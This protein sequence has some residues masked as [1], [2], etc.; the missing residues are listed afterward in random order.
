MLKNQFYFF[1]GGG[2]MGERMRSTDWSQTPLGN[3]EIWPQSLK[4]I[5]SVVLNN[6][7]GMY[8]AWGKEYIQIYNDGYRSILGMPEHP[9]ALG[10]SMRDAFSENWHIIE[11]NFDDVMAGRPLGFPDLTLPL[12]RIGNFENCYYDFSYSPIHLENGE[13]GG[14]LVTVLETTAKKNTQNELNESEKRF[15]TMADNIP[16][17]S[18]MA[19]PDGSVYWYNNKW[20]EYTGTT[21]ETMQGW[22]WQ[23]VYKE[24]ELTGILEEWNESL[25]LGTAFEMIYPIKGKDGLYRQFL[26]RALPVKNEQGLI[27]TWFGTNTDITAQKEAE[28]ELSNSKNKLEFVIEAAK[29][30]TFDYNFISGSLSVN[31]RLKKWFG[32]PAHEEINLKAALNAVAENDKLKVL[33][34]FRKIVK[35]QCDQNHDIAIKVINPISKKEITLNAKFKAFFTQEKQ[36]FSFNGTLE[37][38]TIQSVAQRKLELSESKLRLMILQAP[39]AIAILRGEDYEVE[40][41][42][43]YALELWGKTEEEILNVSIFKAIP[44]LISQGMKSIMDDVITS[45]NRLAIS[46]LP[47]EIIRDGKLKTVYVNFSYEPLFD[48]VGKASGIM[49]IGLDVTKQVLAHQEIQKKE[50]SIR[51]L[52]ESAP[53]PIGVYTGKEMRITFANQSIISSWGTDKDVIGKLYSEIFPEFENQNVY[54]KLEKVFTTGIDF[55]A[56]NQR[57]DVVRDGALQTSYFNYSFTPL[58]DLNGVIYGVMHTAAEVTEIHES[59]E[60]IEESEKRF[61]V[62]VHQAPVAIAIFRGKDNVVEVANK[63]YLELIGKEEVDF[64]GQPLFESLPEIEESIGTIIADIYKTKKAFYGYEFPVPL[65][66]YGK[67]ES[68]FFNF[69][70]HPLKEGKIVTGIMVVATEVTEN[71]YAKK[72]LEENEQRLNIVI[73][74]SGLAIWELDISSDEVQISDRGIEILGLPNQKYINHAQLISKI[75]PDDLVLRKLAFER[76]L[77]TGILHYEIRT[78][79]DD[80]IHWIEAKG[81]VF[82]DEAGKA[83]RILGTLRE[84]TEVKN[85]QIQLLEREQKFRLLAD[86][87]PQF[88]WTA[89]PEGQLN[90]FNQSV[91]D[92]SGYSPEEL[93][94]KGWSDI[95]HVEDRKENISKWMKS[96]LTEKDFLME[97][98]FRK[99]DGSYRW[100]LSRAIPQRDQDGKI[101][102]W[103][104]TSTDIQDQKMFTNELEKQVSQRTRQLHKKNEVLEKMNKELQSFTY[105]SSHDLQEPLRKIQIFASQINDFESKNL[106]DSGK[107]KFRRMQ[108]AAN[109]MQTLIQ[110]LLAYSR[111]TD[112]ERTF[113]MATISQIVEEVKEDLEEEALNKKPIITVVNDCD[114]IVIPFQFT[115][116]IFNL[117][118]NSL[119]FS[120]ENTVPEI[121]IECNVA[122]GADFNQEKLIKNKKYCHLKIQD[123]GIGFEQ[124]YSE[125]IFE[126]FQRLHGKEEYQGTGVGLAIVK[127]IVDNHNGFI[128]ARGV[129][130]EGAV[131]DVYLPF[132]SK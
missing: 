89:N 50:R 53:F 24:D 126:V 5:V 39:I 55:H 95:V 28:D 43:K 63:S 131:F 81:K 115:Q 60:K 54:Q 71:V 73:N 47:I 3:P 2:E 125:K 12:D 46:E 45:T 107:D 22:G 14:V 18:W 103:V 35:H 75:H 76:A 130:N 123:N 91:F 102:M 30:G 20:F 26:T 51:S 117:I 98:R 101:T 32:V 116:L 85:N 128:T 56:N 4:T 113:E 19:R 82:F 120:K 61:R 132:S 34:A 25:R 106:S 38:I 114:I 21:F 40:T 52:V 66:R 62:A 80:G 119:K 93:H 9:N 69:V 58:R 88:V 121:L 16:N 57:V 74:A 84:V 99:S 29:L 118:S 10:N 41:A 6:P 68:C 65:A 49:V 42:N 97:H 11:S 90:Y 1:R 17:L 86:S 110:D 31:S 64:L 100:Q 109:R 122:M 72:A 27:T 33:N 13:V 8:I 111:T 78:I 48:E 83:L 15:K 44:E 108:N 77:K 23:S 104:G 127:K 124:E 96:I 112:Q 7:F 79:V 129:L 67:K 59:K 36:A 92:F 37:D 105:I 94:R 70:Y 87:M